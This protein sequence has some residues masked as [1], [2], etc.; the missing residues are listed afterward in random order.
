[1]RNPGTGLTELREIERHCRSEISG[2]LAEFRRLRREADPDALFAELAFCLFTPQSNA[3]NCWKAVKCL[4]S[5][6]ILHEGPAESVA[7]VLRGLVRFHNTKARRLVHARSIWPQIMDNIR[8]S[9]DGM[10][11]REF[12]VT[13]AP[14]IGWK[15]A[16]HFI[17]NI[18]FG[19]KVA[20][21]DRH[22]LRALCDYGV[23][24]GLP[25]GLSP[26]RYLDIEQQMLGWSKRIG[27]PMDRLDFVL[28]Y[29][30]KREIFK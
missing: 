1:M 7:A 22:I 10:L 27:I 17:R 8:G 12:V 24:C 23:I 18:G 29:R 14:G 5:S 28:W 21:L 15:E 16:S 9:S 19:E 13:L 11:L 20:I 6:G 4:S 25:S 30:V 26:A 3:C 2:R